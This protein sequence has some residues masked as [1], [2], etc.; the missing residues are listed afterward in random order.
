M[1][2]QSQDVLATFR[3]EAPPIIR[4]P[5]LKKTGFPYSPGFMANLASIGQGPP[6][7]RVGRLVCYDR[8][9]LADW[10]ATRIKVEA[11]RV[12]RQTGAA[13]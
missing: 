2:S 10:L 9:A 3:K 7:F 8:D 1:Q 6:F 5:D 12:P 11:P 4:R 13:A